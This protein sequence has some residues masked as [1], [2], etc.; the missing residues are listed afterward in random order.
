M[1]GEVL[2]FAVLLERDS[3]RFAEL[4]RRLWEPMLADEELADG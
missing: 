1:F 3:G 2:P 4:A